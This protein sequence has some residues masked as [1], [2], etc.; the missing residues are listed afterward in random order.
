[1]DHI[2]K[3]TITPVL[4]FCVI[5]QFVILWTLLK[6]NFQCRLESMRN[7]FISSHISEH[8]F[9]PLITTRSRYSVCNWPSRQ[10]T[11]MI[12]WPNLV[13][14]STSDGFWKMHDDLKSWGYWDMNLGGYVC[15]IS[16]QRLVKRSNIC[17]GLSCST[18]EGNEAWAR[19]N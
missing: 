15:G 10:P 18:Q 16:L 6:I 5:N 1:M 12:T 3:A 17:R 8:I 7:M 11:D 13:F 14:P 2:I 9:K 4:A 19:S